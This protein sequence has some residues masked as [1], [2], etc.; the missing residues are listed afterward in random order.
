MAFESWGGGGVGEDGV[1]R[2]IGEVA[3]NWVWRGNCGFGLVCLSW[4]RAPL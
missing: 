3:E 1:A 2:V 4:M